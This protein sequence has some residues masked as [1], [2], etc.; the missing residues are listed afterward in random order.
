MLS[1]VRPIHPEIVGWSTAPRGQVINESLRQVLGK[2]RRNWSARPARA[3]KDQI[4]TDPI[5]YETGWTIARSLGE[6]GTTS[7]HSNPVF[8]CNDCT[9]LDELHRAT[10]EKKMVYEATQPGS[11]TPPAPAS[12]GCSQPTKHAPKWV[13]P[14]P[15][16][17]PSAR[18]KPKSHNHCAALLVRGHDPNDAAIEM[19]DRQM[20]IMPDLRAHTIWDTIQNT[21]E[22]IN[23]DQKFRQNQPSNHPC[24]KRNGAHVATIKCKHY[25]DSPLFE[26]AGFLTRS[27]HALAAGLY[28]VFASFGVSNAQAAD[29]L[30]SAPDAISTNA[31]AT[32]QLDAEAQKLFDEQ[33]LWGRNPLDEAAE[34]HFTGQP[35]VTE[36]K[37]RDETYQKIPFSLLNREAV[38]RIPFEGSQQI[39]FVPVPSAVHMGG[40]VPQKDPLT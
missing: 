11:A 19:D 14:T 34:R 23:F 15:S 35:G 21:I 28:F 13:A 32:G 20:R 12:N 37:V 6:V 9:F 33:K 2:S 25:M 38:I 30:V 4:I 22:V 17:L 36:Y 40:E 29:C 24:I 27:N 8:A 7:A 26:K 31:F 18:P 5:G 16:S 39:T 3:G 10:L 1:G